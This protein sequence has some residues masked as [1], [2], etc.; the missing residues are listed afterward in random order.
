MP[1]AR[2]SPD[3]RLAPRGL[4]APL[5]TQRFAARLG[6]WVREAGPEDDVVV[7]CRVRLARNVANYPF[8]A[9]LDES[10]ARELSESLLE[11]LRQRRL[12]GETITVGMGEASGLMRLLLRERHLV[13]RDLAPSD[14]SRPIPP[15]RAVAFGASE[16]LS[17]MINE[18]DHLRLAG[19]APGFDLVGAFSRARELDL[20]LEGEVDFSH[21]E[22]LGYLTGCPTNVGTGLR[23]SVMLHLPAIGML[24]SELER[25]FA[26]AQRTGLAVRGL[27]GEGSRAAGDFYQLSNQVTLGKSEQQLID[28]LG[29]L[30]PHVVAYE[31]RVREALL[32]DRREALVDRV[33]GARGKLKSTRSMPTEEALRHLS[34]VRLGY[35]LGLLDDQGD[36]RDLNPVAI[37]V[38]KGHVQ[39]LESGAETS[40]L[41]EVSERDRLRAVFLRRQFA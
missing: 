16:T 11:L 7:S 29:S 2:Q 6:A 38:Q 33:F 14:P 35:A 30:V 31:R 13:S 19:F 3:R 25:F 4:K 12:D 17:A 32:E 18:E 24:R 34:S 23:A 1:R 10:R 20:S 26:A 8:V 37:Q 9:K 15:G 36:A 21:S 39:A 41:L 27:Y 22:R 40:S 28:D 5:E